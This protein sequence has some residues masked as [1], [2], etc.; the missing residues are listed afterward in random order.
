LI[1]FT[2]S[3]QSIFKWLSLFYYF[4]FSIFHHF[5]YV[6]SI[7]Q[8]TLI[9]EVQVGER[10]KGG[11]DSHREKERETCFIRMSFKWRG[12]NLHHN[13]LKS[14]RGRHKKR[15]RRK[16]KEKNPHGRGAV[17]INSRKRV[18]TQRNTQTSQPRTCSDC[19]KIKRSA[20]RP[21]RQ[22]PRI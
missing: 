14:K 2:S 19:R 7:K 21:T 12:E 4:F 17:L 15:E 22:F 18:N 10:E 8:F 6:V 1:T 9:H 3:Y 16:A 20:G 13:S 5:S 11:R